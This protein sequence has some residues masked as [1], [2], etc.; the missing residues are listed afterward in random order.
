MRIL[1]AADYVTK[2]FRHGELRLRLRAG[3]RIIELQIA[4]LAA[5]DTFR[6]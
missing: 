4:L 5:R 6:T 2:P 1:I 3:R